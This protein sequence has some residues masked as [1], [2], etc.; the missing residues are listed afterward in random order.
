MTEWGPWVLRIFLVA[1]AGTLAHRAGDAYL[2]AGKTEQLEEIRQ[3]VREA[4]DEIAW[5][6]E[7]AAKVEATEKRA[8]ELEAL[9]KETG[10]HLLAGEADR[11]KMTIARDETLNSLPEVTLI[12]SGGLPAPERLVFHPIEDLSGELEALKQRFQKS[13]PQERFQE[14]GGPRPIE[15]LRYLESYRIEATYE[16]ALEYLAKIETSPTYMEVTDLEA[17]GLE[18]T[19]GEKLVR[20]D[21]TLSGLSLPEE[22]TVATGIGSGR[23]TW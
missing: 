8:T 4:R 17:E 5:F 16:A 18:G 12:P 23:V 3:G 20:M 11:L 9:E 22:P 14:W 13:H 2:V 19:G 6:R 15:V 21:L 10:P 7:L 1:F